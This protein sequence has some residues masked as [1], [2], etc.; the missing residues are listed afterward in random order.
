MMLRLASLRLSAA[1]AAGAAGEGDSSIKVA[2]GIIMERR[3]WAAAGGD[4]RVDWV[5][6][7]KDH[8]MTR[9]LAYRDRDSTQ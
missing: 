7:V 2:K 9:M 5:V 3:G 1:G 8:A 6:A 4:I